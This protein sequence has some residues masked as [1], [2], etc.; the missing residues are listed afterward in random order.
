[1]TED[2]YLGSDA[3]ALAS[4]VRSGEISPEELVALALARIAAVDPVLAP[5]RRSMPRAP[6]G[7]L[8]P[9]S[10]ELPLAGV[11]FLVKDT[12]QDVAGF[13]TRHGSCFYAD[14]APA[15]ADS[16]FVARLRA[17]RNHHSRP[18]QDTGIRQRFVTEPRFGGT[19]AQSLE[20]GAFA[21]RIERRRCRGVAGGMVPAAHGTDCGGINPGPRRGLRAVRGSSR[22]AAAA[23]KDRPPQSA[24][25]ASMSNSC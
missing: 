10:P 4:L 5:S 17:C 20:P 24:S 8:P 1:M 19:G 7:Q 18:E 16:D 23:R 21:R 25:A 11:P 6:A 12:N 3:V 15:M 2:D 13:A 22:A 9:S 14:A